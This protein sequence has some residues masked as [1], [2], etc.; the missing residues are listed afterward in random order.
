MITTVF[1]LFVS[2]LIFGVASYVFEGKNV[3]RALLIVISIALA[4]VAGFRDIGVDQDSVGYFLYYNLDDARMA[5]AAEP[6][7]VLIANITRSLF[8]SD[9]FRWLLLLYAIAGV[10]LKI[11]AISKLSKLAWLSIL[12]YVS[13]Y[14]LLHEVTQI[15]AGVASG[16]VLFSI[17]YIYHRRIFVFLSLVVVASLFHYS[18]LVALPLYFLRRELNAPVKW[19]IA[20]AVPLG[21]AIRAIGINILYVVPVQLVES[22]IDTYTQSVAYNSVALNVFN[23]VYLIKYV[24]L[25]VFLFTNRNM[26]EGSKYF[27]I[28]LQIYALSMFSYLALSYNASFSIRISEMFGIVE[29]VLYPMLYYFARPRSVGLA[30]VIVLAAG[31]LALGVYQTELIHQDGWQGG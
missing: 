31:N 28:L 9:G 27:P 16:L 17:Y 29:I 12:T 22:K 2:V 21:I 20:V 7:F 19:A 5:Q 4:V 25:Y 8:Q 11:L 18:A 23:A 3:K 10:A 30:A 1:C 13:G 15:R 6:T 24:L 26:R 14:Y